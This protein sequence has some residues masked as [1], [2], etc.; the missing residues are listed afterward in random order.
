VSAT[1]TAYPLAW[2]A[3]K[4]RT[5]V[6]RESAFRG[7]NG[8]YETSGDGNR[9][10][11]SAKTL[12]IEVARTRLQRE[13]ELLGA[14]LPVLSTNIE[15]R[16]DGAPRSGRNA[17]TDPG[18]AVYFQLKGVPVTLAADAYHSVAENIAAIAAHVAAMRT[19]ERHGVGTLE[20]MF[21]GFTALPGAIAGV[22][23]R[24]VLEEPANLF[25]AEAIYR[26]KISRAHPDQPGTG[27]EEAAKLLNAA[28]AA[29]RAHFG[30]NGG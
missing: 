26:A 24:K 10:W 30:T 14:R 29:A 16:V 2:P 17:P 28:I 8:H 19:A 4:P 22:D 20:Q 9:R 5:Q 15:L 23:W 27:D 18:V 21:R 3:G 13:L 12:T 25:A 7:D 11:V 6:R 1:P